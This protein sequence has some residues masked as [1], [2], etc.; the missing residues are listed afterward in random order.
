L[1]DDVPRQILAA[2]DDGADTFC[3]LSKR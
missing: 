3:H 2:P 1:L